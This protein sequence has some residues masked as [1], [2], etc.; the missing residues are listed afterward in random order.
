MEFTKEKAKQPKEHSYYALIREEIIQ[1]IDDQNVISRNHYGAEVLNSE[2]VVFV[3]CD[4]SI[5]LNKEKEE[6]QIKII[7]ASP[8]KGSASNGKVKKEKSPQK[9]SSNNVSASTSERKK[10]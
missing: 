5:K 9:E 8:K 10:D 3:D 1:E 6:I 4:V 2:N 7:K